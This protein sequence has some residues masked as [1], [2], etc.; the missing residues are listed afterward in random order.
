MEP[1][2]C[3]IEGDAAAGRQSRGDHI[4]SPIIPEASCKKHELPQEVQ[5]T[6]RCGHNRI[7]S[8][9]QLPQ[10][11]VSSKSSFSAARSCCSSSFENISL[12]K[13][14]PAFML[15]VVVA[16]LGNFVAQYVLGTGTCRC[17]ELRHMSDALHAEVLAVRL[18]LDECRR[19]QL[20]ESPDLASSDNSEQHSL[21]REQLQI[22]ELVT[23]VTSLG[24][25]DYHSIRLYTSEVQH[26]EQTQSH[27]QSGGSTDKQLKTLFQYA[28]GI[29]LFALDV[30]LLYFCLKSC[31]YQYFLQPVERDK[32]EKGVGGSSSSM[33]EPCPGA[34]SPIDPTGGAVLIKRPER[35]HRCRVPL[36]QA[37]EPSK[38]HF[39]AGA[40]GLVS[41]MCVAVARVTAWATFAVNLCFLSNWLTYAILTLRVCLT[42]LLILF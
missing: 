38:P 10:C 29:G 4:P 9:A 25:M 36:E 8:T 15:G 41:L 23:P 37:S 30:G 7:S 18:Q 32:S 21:G 6:P 1:C 33:K 31:A 20:P 11:Q 19:R 2:A 14:L 39:R 35:S 5:M 26:H 34:L 40:L 16:C 24:S 22:D 28:S 12:L 27:G 3:T 17:T 13:Q 42:V